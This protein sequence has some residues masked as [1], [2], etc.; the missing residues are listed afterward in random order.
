MPS[1][2]EKSYLR[3]M[4]PTATYLPLYGFTFFAEQ[5]SAS[6]KKMYFCRKKIDDE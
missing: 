2:F 6:L 5:F 3:T 4:N 1:L